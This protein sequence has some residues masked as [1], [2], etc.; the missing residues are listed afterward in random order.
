[1]VSC[2]FRRVIE[3][4]EKTDVRPLKHS[5]NETFSGSSV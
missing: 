2:D 3:I 5:R 4:S 1:M